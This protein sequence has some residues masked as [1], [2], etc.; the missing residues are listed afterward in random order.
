MGNDVNILTV[1]VESITAVSRFFYSYLKG[2]GNHLNKSQK[3]AIAPL[4]QALSE[5]VE[6]IKLHPESAAQ[7]YPLVQGILELITKCVNEKG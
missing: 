1:I 2:L 3:N 5:L 7:V 4:Q 6:H